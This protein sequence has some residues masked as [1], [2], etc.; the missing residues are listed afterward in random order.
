MPLD[1]QARELLDAMA[2]LGDPPIQEMTPEEFRSSREKRRR[3]STEPC[4]LVEAIDAGGVP[5]RLYRADDGPDTGLLVYF[6]GGGWVGGSLDS[7]DDVCR[8]LCN[9]SG[10]AVLSVDYRLAPEHPF[11]AGL[12]DAIT[13]T[14]WAYENAAA[15]GCD[16]TRIGIG[17]DSAGG[18]FAAVVANSR[19]IPARFQLLV[20]PA[21]DLRGGF[22]SYIENADGYFLTGASMR[23]FIDHYLSGSE[24]SLDDPLV[25]PLLASDDV[26]AG[27]PPAFV[28]T[29]GYDPLR[30]EGEAYATRLMRAGVR[31][32]L[33][34]FPGM[35]H[36]FFSLGAFLD[37]G[38]RAIN[39]AARFL[40]V[41]TRY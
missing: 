41:E 19:V 20:Y 27:A 35:I 32:A 30:D 17:G 2:A 13:A 8:M 31:A 1:P 40:A 24:G 39:D 34:C 38:Q 22:P 12:E 5:A 3:P 29:A 26:L 23:Y 15:M 10:V 21:T 37:E 25:S 7:H 6:H 14:K 4:H 9:R 18:N 36:G 16:P 28:I 11:P 33:S